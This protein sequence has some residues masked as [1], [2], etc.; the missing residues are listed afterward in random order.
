MKELNN[1]PGVLYK[2]LPF[3]KKNEIDRLVIIVLSI[4][5]IMFSALL[6]TSFIVAIPFV[7]PFFSDIWRDISCNNACYFQQVSWTYIITPLLLGLTLKF[8]M[9]LVQ[10]DV[11]CSHK[12]IRIFLKVCRL[13]FRIILIIVV[14]AMLSESFN[15]DIANETNNSSRWD[16]VMLAMLYVGYEGFTQCL[17]KFWEIFWEKLPKKK[18]N[19]NENTEEDNQIAQIELLKETKEK[20][21]T[22]R[23]PALQGKRQRRQRR[24]RR[25]RY[26]YT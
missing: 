5:I 20:E 22:K 26:K 8:F 21:P 2:I 14:G 23:G 12:I 10:T 13:I 19:K 17:E 18:P 3:L 1:P 16:Y 24:Q 4:F 11:S 7:S 9:V 6:I 15:S 25:R